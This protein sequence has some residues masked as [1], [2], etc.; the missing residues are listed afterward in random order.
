MSLVNP[1]IAGPLL[2]GYLLNWGLQGVLCAQAYS[3]Y[4]AFPKDHTLL[5]FLVYGVLLLETLETGVATSDAFAIFASG[6]LDIFSPSRVHLMWLSVPIHSGIVGCIGQLFFASRIQKISKCWIA[7]CCVVFL[8]VMTSASALAC[9]V[10][11]S[12]LSSLVDVTRPATITTRIWLASN[13]ACSVVIASM[14][15]YYTTRFIP[16]AK[17]FFQNS[18]AC[19]SKQGLFQAPVVAVIDL[20]LY[21]ASTDTTYHTVPALFM[22]KV[23]SNTMLV[24]FNNR[25][26]IIGGRGDTD[27][28]D[29]SSFSIAWLGS[30]WRRQRGSWGGLKKASPMDAIHVRTEVWTDPINLDRLELSYSN[31]ESNEIPG[32]KKPEL[33][34]TGTDDS[35]IV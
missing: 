13:V 27:T 28:G 5:K 29:P 34:H 31:K 19:L 24:V 14:M 16:V 32:G 10:E 22:S 17:R 9:G 3:Y 25:M 20:V 30:R 18:S 12:K 1:K 6:F 2:I 11:Y 7:T 23:Y 21:V 33:S 35:H 4:V 26:S 15:T 8:A